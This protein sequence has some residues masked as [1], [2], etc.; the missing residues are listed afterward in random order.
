MA[1]Y[2]VEEYVPGISERELLLS[3]AR[4][5]Q[6]VAS[7]VATG[8][9]IRYVGTTFVPEQ[10]TS[11]SQFE[12]PSRRLVERACRRAD[13]PFARISEAQALLSKEKEES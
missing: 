1:L 8:E 12:A 2:L 5:E 10:E 9:R 4:L 3:Q 6:A 11:L 7:L 13:I